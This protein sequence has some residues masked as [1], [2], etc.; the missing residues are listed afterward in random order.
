MLKTASELY[1]NTAMRYS[2]LCIPLTPK[3]ELLRL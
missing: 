3:R 1:I 2:V